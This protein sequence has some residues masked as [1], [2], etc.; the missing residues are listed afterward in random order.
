MH[1]GIPIRIPGPIFGASRSS[2]LSPGSR[3]RDASARTWTRRRR[4]RA[5]AH[6][7]RGWGRRAAPGG[8]AKGRYQ[9]GHRVFFGAEN[10]QIWGLDFDE[11]TEKP[12]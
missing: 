11:A 4:G 12:R 7:A 10:V 9:L 1:H 6:G 8:E 3:V 5:A 2:D